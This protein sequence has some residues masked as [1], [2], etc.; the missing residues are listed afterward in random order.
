MCIW[1]VFLGATV[2]TVLDGVNAKPDLFPE[3]SKDVP[4]INFFYRY[5]MKHRGR[6]LCVMFWS[7]SVLTCV[8]FLSG[9]LRQQPHVIRVAV[10]SSLFAVTQR[11][12]SVVNSL[13]PGVWT[14]NCLILSVIIIIVKITWKYNIIMGQKCLM[15]L[16]FTCVELNIK[17]LYVCL[18]SSCPAGTCDGCTFH[19]LWESAS[20]CPRCTEDDYHQIEGACKGGVQVTQHTHHVLYTNGSTLCSLVLLILT[21]FVCEQHCSCFKL[22]FW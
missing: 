13:C 2:D 11:T 5:S 4:D 19:F 20:A 6:V 8:F 18:C 12:L 17:M 10:Q 7:I 22:H 21:Y 1:F 15:G 14:C 3:N 16:M 9:R